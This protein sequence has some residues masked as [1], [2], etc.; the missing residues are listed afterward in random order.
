MQ[1]GLYY[2]L[3]KRMPFLVG[4]KMVS[5]QWS[6]LNLDVIKISGATI[7]ATLIF[8]RETIYDRNSEAFVLAQ[9]S[10]QKI[11]LVLS[12]TKHIYS[13]LQRS[14]FSVPLWHSVKGRF[15]LGLGPRPGYGLVLGPYVI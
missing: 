8:Q 10:T 9:L 5:E 1:R 13:D 7:Y 14:R 2:L 11:L 6:S 4:E 12:S 3:H 15:L